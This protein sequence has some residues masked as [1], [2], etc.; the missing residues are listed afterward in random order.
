VARAAVATSFS[1]QDV[2]A[3]IAHHLLRRSTSHTAEE[4]EGGQP[5]ERGKAH[6]HFSPN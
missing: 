1:W 5:V 4:C 6:N 3:Y 2:H